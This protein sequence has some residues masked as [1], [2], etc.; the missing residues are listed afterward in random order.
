MNPLLLNIPG[1]NSDMSYSAVQ[2][3]VLAYTQFMKL[4]YAKDCDLI[5]INPGSPIAQLVN[6]NVR[7]KVHI[8]DIIERVRFLFDHKDGK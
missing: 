3:A 1:V 5:V 4:R 8:L 2:S 7:G 6:M